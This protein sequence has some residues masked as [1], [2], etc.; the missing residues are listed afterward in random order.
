MMGNFGWDFIYR[1][2]GEEFMELADWICGCFSQCDRCFGFL[3]M[4]R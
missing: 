4:N 1:D 2:L 3:S